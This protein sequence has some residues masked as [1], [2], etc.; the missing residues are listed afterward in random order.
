[1]QQT[2]KLFKPS[3]H[4]HQSSIGSLGASQKQSYRDKKPADLEYGLN[5][6]HEV[7]KMPEMFT[8]DIYSDSYS[9]HS[10]KEEKKYRIEDIV[11]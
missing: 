5:I 6:S 8:Q 1:M 2:R 9:N 10:S 3:Q 4:S 11:K 7:Q